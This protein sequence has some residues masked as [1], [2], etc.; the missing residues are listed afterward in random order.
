MGSLLC[1]CIHIGWN[2]A[3]SRDVTP[4]SKAISSVV[5]SVTFLNW[6]KSI[7][8]T[9]KAISISWALDP[10]K[11]WVLNQQKLIIQPTSQTHQP[12]SK[13]WI[14]MMFELICKYHILTSEDHTM[15]EMYM[16]MFI[17]V[18]CE[19]DGEECN[20]AWVR[21]WVVVRDQRQRPV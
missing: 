19:Y 2:D 15:D 1:V 20:W 13:H 3:I 7:K 10:V 16:T 4:L 11:N 21:C 8:H 9:H 17:E 14:S 12:N 6:K 18:E 5:Y